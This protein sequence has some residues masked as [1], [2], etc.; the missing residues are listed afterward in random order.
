MTDVR[1]ERTATI[2]VDIHATGIPGLVQYTLW[3]RGPVELT[4]K[5][6]IR[7]LRAAADQLESQKE[8]E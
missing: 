5:E 2:G 8:P 1:P 3:A 7:V 6:R 4:H